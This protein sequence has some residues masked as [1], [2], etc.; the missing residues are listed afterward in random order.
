MRVLGVLDVMHGDVVRGIGG[1][2]SEYRPLQSQL[3]DSSR[4]IDVAEAFRTRV[5]LTELYLADLDAIAGAPPA[6]DLY[7]SLHAAG[8]RLW[9]DAGLRTWRDAASLAGVGV[10]KVVA[11]LETLAGPKELESLCREYGSGAI[12]F[13]LDL[14][15][16]DPLGATADWG[17]DP[18]QIASTAADC[19]AASI[20][21]LDLTR[22]GMGEGTG[23][24]ELLQRVRA[25]RPHVDWLVGGGVRNALDLRRLKALGA[26]GV[27][28]ASALHDGRIGRDD[29][30][31]CQV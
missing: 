3:V 6:V 24:E 25:S 27:L 30:A 20:I 10:A 26:R 22:V 13:S 28:L 29:L 31:E 7:R 19:G 15:A 17:G 12:A 2:R 14:R 16:G 8:F 5:G 21:L 11:G 4:P 9:V 1:Q 23:T 18:Q